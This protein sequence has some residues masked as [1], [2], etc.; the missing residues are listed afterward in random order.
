M[1]ELRF[2]ILN[3]A[4]A[5]DAMRMARL[6]IREAPTRG[7]SPEEIEHEKNLFRAGW[8]RRL[9]ELELDDLPEDPFA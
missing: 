4:S 3:R 9:S 6:S 2:P 7:F 8:K 1:S 5:V